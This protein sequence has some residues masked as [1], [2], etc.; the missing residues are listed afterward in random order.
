[1][2]SC[3]FCIRTENAG[4]WLLFFFV[5]DLKNNQNHKGFHMSHGSMG[6]SSSA[7]PA[8]SLGSPFWVRKHVNSKK[9]NLFFQKPWG[10]LNPQR[11]I[12]QDS[13]PNTLP[14]AQYRPY[15]ISKGTDQQGASFSH[16]LC[17][18]ILYALEAGKDT[19][20]FLTHSRRST[21]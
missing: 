1:M 4:M 11:C 5:F 8:I 9:K 7:F 19:I 3:K 17:P 15:F 14:T 10:G 12:I 21:R 18:C 2:C 6:S 13:E 16:L 20:Q